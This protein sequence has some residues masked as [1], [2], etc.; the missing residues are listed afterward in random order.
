[1]ADLMDQAA[2]V[3]RRAL[4]GGRSGEPIVSAAPGGGPEADRENNRTLH[5]GRIGNRI[6]RG[7]DALG[8]GGHGDAVFTADDVD[9][10]VA[11]LVRDHIA[12]TQQRALR[13]PR[14]SSRI[15]MSKPFSPEA[16]IDNNWQFA[17]GPFSIFNGTL[18]AP[19]AGNSTQTIPI[20]LGAGAISPVILLDRYPGAMYMSV[21]VRS[22]A[23]MPTAGTMT[24]IQECWFTDTGGAV[25]GLGIY[26][27]AATSAAVF[28]N[29]GALCTSPLTD[30]G[31]TQ[32]GTITVNNIGIATP[33]SVRWQLTIS[34]VAFY[35][36]PWFNEQVV[37]PP[38]PAEIERVYRSMGAQGG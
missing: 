19:S 9:T 18:A 26:N 37:I 17:T 10:D 28:Q 29:I 3:I 27:A 21:Y 25:A 8:Y 34:F 1:M 31:N 5:G 12:A 38:T 36:D 15:R 6:V 14:P 13:E 24:G 35:A 4:D 16:H 33:V 2:A 30:P 22:F 20:A 23:F 32:I 7:R 11:Q